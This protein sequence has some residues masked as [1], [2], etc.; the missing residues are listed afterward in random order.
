MQAVERTPP[1]TLASRIVPVASAKAT[2][3]AETSA[4]SAAA[5]EA[6]NLASTLSGI[7]KLLLDMAAEETSAAAEKVM[8][9]VPD[10]GKRLLIL[11][12]KKKILTFGTWW[13]KN[14]LRLTRRRYRNMGYP[15][16]TSQE[17]CFL[18][19][20]TKKPWDV[21]AIMLGRK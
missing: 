6:T 8:T 7:D 11:L 5:A 17:L 10:K 14:C 13:V 16:A 19:E 4:E 2:A 15:V 12:Q 21:F 1:L 18:V 3:E 20:L 9:T